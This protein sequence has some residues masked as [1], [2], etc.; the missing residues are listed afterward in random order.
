VQSSVF[1]ACDTVNVWPATVATAV[2][3]LVVGFASTL[4]DAGP[5]PV[6]DG[7]VTVSQ[8]SVLTAVQSQAA[9]D[10]VIV[11]DAEPPAAATFWPVG[12]SEYVHVFAACVTVN[13]CPATV[14]VPLR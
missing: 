8:L 2:R 4:N 14:T 13:V 6:P 11:V 7:V 10:A 3:G 9:S 12:E 5:V 1:A